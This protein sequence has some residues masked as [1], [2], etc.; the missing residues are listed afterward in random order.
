MV[1]GAAT[2]ALR[3]TKDDGALGTIFVICAGA[4]T[5]LG[6]PIGAEADTGLGCWLTAAGIGFRKSVRATSCAF[7]AFC[8]GAFSAMRF[9]WYNVLR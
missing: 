6:G 7:C 3:N 9:S 2:V 8:A 1:T 4:D 5:G